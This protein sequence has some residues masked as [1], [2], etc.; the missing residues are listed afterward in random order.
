MFMVF[1][2]FCICGF[3]Q[4]R[5]CHVSPTGSKLHS[6]VPWGHRLQVHVSMS[7]SSH[8]LQFSLFTPDSL[9][10]LHSLLYIYIWVYISFLKQF[11]PYHSSAWIP[12]YRINSESSLCPWIPTPH[13]HL[14][15]LYPSCMLKHL[16]Y[17]TFVPWLF[18]EFNLFLSYLWNH[19]F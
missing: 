3:V 8:F 16:G 1:L 11:I 6:S 10:Y 2:L 7:T 19:T 4:T 12:P 5:S 15:Y 17:P 9:Q 13:S 18:L 14:V